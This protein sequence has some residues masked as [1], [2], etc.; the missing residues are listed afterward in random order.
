MLAM[1]F[2]LRP[3]NESGELDCMPNIKKEQINITTSIQS[4]YATKL[5]DDCPQSII[6][7]FSEETIEQGW[8]IRGS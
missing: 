4:L 3:K 7:T 8:A 2:S 5:Q 6:A 1:K